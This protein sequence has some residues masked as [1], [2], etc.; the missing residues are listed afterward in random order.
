MDCTMS[1]I[2]TGVSIYFNSHIINIE[3]GVLRHNIMWYTDHEE[4]RYY[5]PR[6]FPHGGISLPLNER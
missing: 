2:I 4:G 6:P 1:V 3:S 5:M